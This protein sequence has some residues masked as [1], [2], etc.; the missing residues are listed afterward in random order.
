MSIKILEASAGS[1][2]TYQLSMFFVKLALESPEKFKRIL[3]ITF[4]NAAVN[5]MKVRILDRLYSLSIKNKKSLDEFKAFAPDGKINGAPINQSTDEDI[6]TAAK[7][8]LF[9]ILHNYQD[10]SVSTIDS[11]LQKLFRGALYE[12]GIRYN[13]E[14]IVKSDDV[15]EEAV[16]DFIMSLQ[17]NDP[18]FDWLVKFIEDKLN[19]NKSFD[20]TMLLN[21]LTREI[22]KEFF[23]DYEDY[24]ISKLSDED[25]Q[26]LSSELNRKMSDFLSKVKIINQDFYQIL[27]ETGFREED[28]SNGGNGTVKYIGSKLEEIINSRVS[29]KVIRPKPNSNFEK[30]IKRKLSLF[31]NNCNNPLDPANQSKII[32]LMITFYD[33]MNSDDYKNYETARILSKQIYNVA[34]LSHIL[35][36]LDNY[37]KTNNILLLSDIGRMLKSFIRDNYMFIYEKLGVYYEYFLIDEF[38][39]TSRVQYEIIKPLIE[40]SISAKDEEN[41]LL[42]GDIKQAIYR[43]RNGD[44]EIMK[45]TIDYDFPNSISRNTLKE[46]WRSYPNIIRFNNSLFNQLLSLNNLFNDENE[47]NEMLDYIRRIYIDPN[48]NR[49]V[50]QQ[51]PDAKKNNFNN[52]E[53]YVKLYVKKKKD[54]DKTNEQ[55]Y[56]NI[57]DEQDINALEL[58]KNDVGTLWE[59]G[60]KNIGI[61]VRSNKESA[62]IFRYLLENPPVDDDDFKIISQE[63]ITYAN[64]DAVLWIV[65]TLYWLQNGSKYA[66]YMSKAFYE[67]IK[68]SASL[69]YDDIINR[70]SN[71]ENFLAQNLYFKAEHL[72]NL[73][74]SFINDRERAFC[75]HF[76]QLIKNYQQEQSNNEVM[77][78]YWFLKK[79][80]KESVKISE[81]GN[82]VHITTIHR[83]KGLEYDAVIVPSVNWTRNQSDYMWFRKPQFLN[84]TNVPAFLLKATK[85]FNSSHFAYEYSLENT[86]NNV[87]DLNLLYVALTR[88]KKVLIANIDNKCIGNEVLKCINNDFEIEELGKLSNY[89]SQ[90][91]I[92]NYDLYEIGELVKN[93]VDTDSENISPFSWN[94]KK[95]VNI[96][97]KIKQNYGLS[98]RENIA[99]GVLIHDILRSIDDINTWEEKANKI[100]KKHH[101]TIDDS[102]KIKTKIRNIL[103][104]NPNVRDWFTKADEIISERD[105]SYAGKM[106]RP[107][108]VFIHPD[109]IILVDFKTGETDLKDY[110]NQIK[111]YIDILK[112]TSN[113]NIEGYLLNIDRNELIN[114]EI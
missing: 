27:K 22:N 75:L 62:S 103:N 21:A 32:D 23:Y 17:K 30:V 26:K 86:K 2:K 107:D 29:F 61:L 88:A 96:E 49:S 68:A 94:A 46:N 39:D 108:K 28:F 102:E 18:A 87:D 24:F 85:I 7:N 79:G 74:Y 71:D 90:N 97:I 91:T 58:L 77:F 100:L 72:V 48:K 82:G 37:K 104:V 40:E 95:N 67:N 36:N 11:F 4:T 83:S 101:K 14:L 76:L 12:I 34:L 9:N 111:K 112:Q 66:S 60:Y 51:I 110:K 105:I 78:I 47:K 38:Q 57:D 45:E 84:E 41:V 42:V 113:K 16:N 43:W 99:Y 13:Y 19:D 50:K 54:N 53:G 64:S 10:F 5:E 55:N 52:F 81:E 70:L 109:K 89:K 69:S 92:K 35:K 98:T 15:Y 106:L 59:K 1:G 56:E 25:F 73:I 20:Y 114:L 63:S 44:W 33:L 80:I 6:S 65:F 8:V 93:E 3:A 31:S